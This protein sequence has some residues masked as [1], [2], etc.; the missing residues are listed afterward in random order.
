[1]QKLKLTLLL[2]L[3]C[4]ALR[5]Q[6]ID[7][8][9]APRILR[10]SA[11]YTI[12]AQP[13][14]KL[15]VVSPT[16][17]FVNNSPVNVVFRLLE[18]GEV[19]T[20]FHYPNQLRNIPNQVRVQKDGKIIIGG[21]FVD[22]TGKYIASLLRLLPNGAIDPSF[23]LLAKSGYTV[24][25]ISILPSQKIF[26]SGFTQGQAGQPGLLYNALLFTRDGQPDSKFTGISFPADD[27]FTT[28]NVSDLGF[29][30]LNEL[31]IA[32]S[33]LQIGA[34]TQH[35]FRVD[36][37][38]KVDPNFNPA[39]VSVSNFKIRNIGILNDGTI[40][41][42]AG[43]ESNVTLFDR[44]GNR[45]FAQYLPNSGSFLHPLGKTS[46]VVSGERMF[47]ISATGSFRQ[48]FDFGAN[49]YVLAAATQSDNRVVF[50][51]AFS[52]IGN[53]FKAGL[54]RFKGGDGMLLQLDNTFTG[55]LYSNGIVSD[56]LKQK[57]G[58]LVIG[59]FFHL[60]NGVRINHIA[61]L[62][63]NG[64]VDPTF[65]PFL[66]NINRN[67]YAIRQQSDGNLVIAGERSTNFDGLLNG[68]N[69]TDPNGYLVRAP[70]FPFV[71][72]ATGISYLAVDANDKIYAAE[73]LAYS[74]NGKGGQALVRYSPI[75]ILE[76]DYNQLYVNNLFRFNGLFV[77][78]DQKLLLY[79]RN[80]RYDNSDTT[81]IVRVLATGGRDQSFQADF[82]KTAIANTAI[83]IDSNYTLMGGYIP[84]GFTGYN[85]FLTKF[86]PDG[87][88]T[89]S[90]SAD[91]KNSQGGYADVTFLA[92]LPRGKI[93]VSGI[94][95]RYNGR[96]VSNK[97]TIDK[98]GQFVSHFL[99]ELT[100]AS[101]S[102]VVKIDENNYYLGGYFSAPN[103]A[104][105]LIKVKDINT[106]I[107]KPKI[108][109]QSK[110]GKIFPNPTFTE[111]LNLQLDASSLTSDLQFQICELAS[112]K[113]LQSGRIPGKPFTAF[114]LKTLT[115]GSY[116]LHL[117]GEK[118][119]ETHVFNK[120]K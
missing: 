90:F 118:W 113:V 120:V 25:S 56:V 72:S 46:F 100:E 93:L 91:V 65:N 24:S 42:L 26:I 97:I 105:G 79:G 21:S 116:V 57:D 40:G 63:S 76:A 54:V 94:F 50:T 107:E 43:D 115:N 106:A 78:P 3:G 108:L 19:D 36:T 22:P 112:G 101:F 9:F 58:K 66:A 102:S 55:G 18:N 62:T 103:G 92:E 15:L 119:E 5:A 6:V 20:S 37:L 14:N 80:L 88:K 95:D 2:I 74:S 110:K 12:A 98:N 96:T 99:P 33:N 82:A 61:R 45:I 41:V 8:A 10:A 73:G 60:I 52:Q 86:N 11:G 35:I 69:I 1:M 13:D 109:A 104:I 77:Q 70:S 68:I 27:P 28:V 111:T 31:I 85:G 83:S 34:R 117:I 75:G 64:T 32:G 48:I 29:Q 17:G 47:E 7:P 87:K 16:Q 114:D 39:I 84:I 44:N 30:S 23:K 49:Q 51:G 89:T 53:G 71:G 4:V 38:G 59:G 81:A 67:I